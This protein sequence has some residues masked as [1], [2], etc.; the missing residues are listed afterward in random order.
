M[1]GCSVRTTNG[2]PMKTSA[3][4]MPSGVNAT[5]IPYFSSGAPSHPF[6]AYSVVRVMPATAVGSANGKSMNA[7]TMR[8]PGNWYGPAPTRR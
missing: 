2:S 6:G 1:T 7:S 8:L 4:V 3:T 5:L